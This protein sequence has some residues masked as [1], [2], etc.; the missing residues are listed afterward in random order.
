MTYDQLEKEIRMLTAQE[1][2][3]LARTLIEDL[4]GKTDENFEA[5]WAEESE[6]RYKAFL[7]GELEAVPA[8]E[9]I[10]SAKQRSSMKV[11]RPD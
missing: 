7:D 6:R 2:A 4:D 10:A 9:V 5:A 11:S 1:K 3:A 8:E